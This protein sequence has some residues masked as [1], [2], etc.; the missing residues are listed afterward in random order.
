M[1]RCCAYRPDVT[2]PRTAPKKKA[3]STAVFRG[4]VCP[5]TAAHGNVRY[6]SSGGCVA[7]A[8]ERAAVRQRQ[9]AARRRA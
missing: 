6:I 7:C 1:C 4:D 8:R 9:P 2:N 5:V 3:V